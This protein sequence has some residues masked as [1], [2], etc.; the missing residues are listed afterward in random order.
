MA[1]PA[2]LPPPPL[3]KIRAKL[4]PTGALPRRRD[5]ERLTHSGSGYSSFIPPPIRSS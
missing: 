1:D 4:F 2:P 3:V 5:L